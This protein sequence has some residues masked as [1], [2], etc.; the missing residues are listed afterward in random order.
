MD[1]S[2][3]DP[4]TRGRA[5][6]DWLADVLGHQPDLQPCGGDAGG[7]RYFVVANDARWLAVNAPPQTENTAQFLLVAKLLAAGGVR[8]PEVRFA[9]A[10]N[11]FLLVENLGQNLLANAQ[12]PELQSLWYP[13]ALSTLSRIAQRPT[14]Q[15]PQFDTAFIRRELAIFREWF[16]DKLLGVSIAGSALRSLDVLDT[17]LAEC[18]LSQPRV[19]MHRDYHARNLILAG[20][21]VAVIDFQ[22]AVAGPLVYDLVSLLKD[23]YLTL[24]PDQVRRWA[25]SYKAQAEALELMAVTADDEFMRVF[26]W[27]GLQRHIKVLGIFAR[28]YLRDDKPG[29]LADLPRVLHYV[30]DVLAR[31]PEFAEVHQRFERDLA[32]VYREQPWYLGEVP[33][34][35]PTGEGQL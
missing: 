15:L 13:R 31:Y 10:H 5:L 12:T 20:E 23:C 16:V 25:L 27:V 9:D 17:T 14:G 3:T 35:K 34:V 1:V 18:A 8:V 32:P 26:D 33:T 6:R 22:D 7:R 30:L 19:F 29:Y 11:G 24:P 21:D 4:I 2:S 28:L